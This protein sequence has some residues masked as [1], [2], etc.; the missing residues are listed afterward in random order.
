[1]NPER[2]DNQLAAADA[3]SKRGKAPAA[4][5]DPLHPGRQTRIPPGN[6][7]HVLRGRESGGATK[8]SAIT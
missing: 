1:M 8:N 2:Q 4:C 6:Q 7:R 5:W 3:P